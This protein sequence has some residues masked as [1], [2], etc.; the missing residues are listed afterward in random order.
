[1]FIRLH[2]KE[3]APHSLSR[4]PQLRFLLK[5]RRSNAATGQFAFTTAQTVVWPSQFSCEDNHRVTIEVPTAALSLVRTTG[6]DNVI[7][8]LA[9]AL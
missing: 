5:L 9:I 6:C 1:M 8:G 7:C 3:S 4:G 2:A